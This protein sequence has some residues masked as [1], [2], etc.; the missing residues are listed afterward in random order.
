MRLARFGPAG[1]ECPGIIDG[2]GI[3]RD[4]SGHVSDWTGDNLGPDVLQ[5]INALD[6]DELPIVPTGARLGACVA[7]PGKFICIGLN[8]HCN[9]ESL[10]QPIPDEPVIA[11][12]PLSAICGPNDGIELPRSSTRTDW[13]VE[14]GIVI[15]KPAKYIDEKDARSHVAGYCLIN[16]L[17]DRDLQSK[18]GGDTSKGRGHDS[19]GPIGPHFVPAHCIADPQSLDLWLEIDG[20]RAQNGKTANMIFGVDY[21][22]AYLSQFMTLLPGDIIASGTPAGIGIGSKPPR[23]LAPGQTVR[24]GGTGLGEQHHV[25]RACAEHAT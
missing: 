23:F 12:K 3:I 15:G 4:V 10:G 18:R 25:V 9:A 2:K 17:A 1:A 21:L 22:V 13:E 8:Y 6:P 16:D 19:F 11:M 20:V 14:L 24:L 5:K 7:R